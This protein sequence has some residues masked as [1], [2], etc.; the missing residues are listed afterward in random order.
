[1]KKI[2]SLRSYLFLFSLIMLCFSRVLVFAQDSAASASSSTST[3]TTTTEHA[4]TVQPWVWVVGGIV[5]LL[6]IIAL[7]RGKG[8]PESHTDK[9]TYTK[10]TSSDS[11]S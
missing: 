11:N 3:T 4:T 2:F 7:V 8:S 9:V 10:T 6:I 1:M 5:L